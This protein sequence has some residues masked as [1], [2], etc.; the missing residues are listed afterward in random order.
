MSEFGPEFVS[1]KRGVEEAILM[2]K[3]QL[4]AVIV[5]T[6][7][8]AAP[9]MAHDGKP[10]V[11]FLRFGLSLS[12]AS[13][14]TAVIDT[15]LV[16]EWVTAE[17]HALLNERQDIEG[18]KI[19]IF[20]ADASYDLTNVNI[21]VDNALDRGADILLTL[22]TPVTQIALNTTLD[23]DEST[24][25][26]FSAV[27]SPYHAGLADAPCIKPAHVSGSESVPPYE[28]AFQIFLL[29][30]PAL[31]RFGLI[32]SSNDASG[33]YGAETIAAI[34][35]SLGLEVESAAVTSVSDLRSATQSL[36]NEG[37][38]AIILPFDY[39]V[40][41]GLPIIATVAT[42]NQIPVFHPH[43]GSVLA[44]ATVGAGFYNFYTQ[45][46]STGLMLT[47]YLNGDL[48]LA[49]TAIDSQSG[50]SVGINLDVANTLGIDIPPELI[51]MAE[52]VV[53]DGVSAMSPLGLLRLLDS[54]GASDEVKQMAAA[55]LQDV[56]LS[57]MAS[58]SGEQQQ[59]AA[60]INRM[61]I[62]GRKSP[63]NMAADRAYLD[64]L[65][66]TPEM[67]AEQQ[68][69]LDAAAP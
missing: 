37:V 15:L 24:P 27:Y 57:A 39:T 56:D 31:S 8:L 68:A 1:L 58:Q 40:A 60:M 62:E 55:Y 23:Q 30:N 63:E 36:A 29:Q 41:I 12:D 7:W 69:E 66:C 3:R 18:E 17:E 42:E 44:G 10:T 28:E 20:W 4:I 21:M 49:T 19:N 48:D 5:L 54:M 52:M 47:A 14:E 43:P 51:D 11:A 35:E 53:Q 22:S 67:V 59:A 65:Q 32:Y 2:F 33:I 38:E 64:S 34:G 61:L 25:V 46:I 13:L 45:G 16:Y 9:A 6:F 50:L 26:L